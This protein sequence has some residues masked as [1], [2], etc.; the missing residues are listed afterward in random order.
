[1]AAN[2]VQQAGSAHA[3]KQAQ[4]NT[5]RWHGY[6]WLLIMR[7]SSHSLQLHASLKGRS[8]ATSPI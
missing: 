8:E 4:L 6:S 3:R 2:S 1:V 7:C 5:Q